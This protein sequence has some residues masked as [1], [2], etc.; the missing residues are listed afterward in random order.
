LEPVVR[1]AMA[2]A[3]ER[4]GVVG[5]HAVEFR[6]GKQHALDAVHHG[7]VRGFLAFALRVVLAVDGYPFLGDHASSEPEPEPEEMRRNRVQ[8][9][10]AVRLRTMQ[11]YRYGND[12]DVRHSQGVQHNLPPGGIGDAI[13]QEGKDGFHETSH[14]AAHAAELI[15]VLST[16]PR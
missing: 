15:S 1:R 6:A 13:G 2:E 11:K 8:V 10:T 9:E 14:T 7:R 3:L 16:A 12:G 5:F 4:L